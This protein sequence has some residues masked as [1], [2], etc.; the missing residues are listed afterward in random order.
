MKLDVN[1]M[2]TR[3]KFTILARIV[4][5]HRVLIPIITSYHNVLFLKIIYYRLIMYYFSFSI[6]YKIN[7]NYTLN[8]I[9]IYN[10]ILVH[11]CHIS[12]RAV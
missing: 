7:R 1:G 6:V 12:C 10:G 8:M 9:S 4:I 11:N 2:N 5:S 3:V